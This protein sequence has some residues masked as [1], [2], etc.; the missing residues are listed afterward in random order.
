MNK[1]TEIWDA[2]RY[3]DEDQVRRILGGAGAVLLLVVV[4]YGGWWWWESR[5]QP[6]PSIFDSPVDDALGYL[7][8]DDF[9]QLS[10]EDRM[11]YLTEFAQRFRG[12]EQSESASAASFLAGLT[13]PTREQMR[14]NVRILAKDIL[15]DGAEGYL[16][17]PEDERA[18]F[19]DEWLVRWTRTGE[20]MMLGEERSLSDEERLERMQDRSRRDIERGPRGNGEVPEVDGENAMRFIE[21]WQSDVEV[22]STP[23][24]Q[25][26]IIRFLEDLRGHIIKPPGN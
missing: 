4:G 17:L 16:N 7:A 26:Q 12:M 9:N 13:G 24:E 11:K 2:I 20:T 8:L 6:P 5:W 22:A 1:F 10:L 25:G 14:Q 19:L 15:L 18:K 23:R 21:F 3:A